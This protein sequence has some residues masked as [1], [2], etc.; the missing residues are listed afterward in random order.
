MSVVI[1]AYPGYDGEF[2]P[3]GTLHLNEMKKGRKG[4]GTLHIAGHLSGLEPSVSGAG[5]HV[6][7][8][9]S[10]DDADGVGGHLML[11]KDGPDPW[12][13]VTYSTNPKG[14]TK[15]LSLKIPGFS[16]GEGAE[17]GVLGHALVVHLDDNTRAGCGL[18][19]G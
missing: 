11:D 17:G 3:S 19:V 6:H 7:S 9:T 18:I 4:G 16:L 8:G 15:G 10:C 14:I 12:A 5:I 13:D 1:G 2:V